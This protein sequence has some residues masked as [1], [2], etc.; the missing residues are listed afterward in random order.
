MRAAERKE[1]EAA[2][3]CRRQRHRHRKVLPPGLFASDGPM[4]RAVREDVWQCLVSDIRHAVMLAVS[5]QSCL[6]AVLAVPDAVY[7]H[8]TMSPCR[9]ICSPAGCE[10]IFRCMCIPGSFRFQAQSS[11]LKDFPAQ[12]LLSMAISSRSC[13]GVHHPLGR[14]PGW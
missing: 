4:F 10:N 11:H 9:P 12:L 7:V 1:A 8:Y 5:V 13:L 2:R 3:D 6:Y 14:S